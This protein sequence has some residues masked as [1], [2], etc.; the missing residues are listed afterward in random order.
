MEITVMSSVSHRMA[1]PNS[2]EGIVSDVPTLRTTP[3][4]NV[5]PEMRRKATIVT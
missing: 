1:E 5:A 4:T 3:T 2:R